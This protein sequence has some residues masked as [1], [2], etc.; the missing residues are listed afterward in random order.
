MMNVMTIRFYCLQLTSFL[1][2]V[3]GCISFVRVVSLFLSDV[4]LN[5]SNFFVIIF[6]DVFSQSV[7]GAVCFK[8]E[9]K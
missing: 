1:R 7:G 5:S 6:R 3:Y 9:H 2:E 8:A 4:A